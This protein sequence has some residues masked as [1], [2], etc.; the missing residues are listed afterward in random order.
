MSEQHPT[1][2]QPARAGWADAY[3]ADLVA[4]AIEHGQTPATQERVDAF[5]AALRA[6]ELDVRLEEVKRLERTPQIYMQHR[7]ASRLQTLRFLRYGTVQ[8]LDE[9]GDE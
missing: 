8:A 5:R 2:P 6:R 3:L 4:T 9:D 7:I 1:E